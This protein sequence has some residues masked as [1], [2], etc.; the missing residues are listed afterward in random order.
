[1]NPEYVPGPY[2]EYRGVVEID[3]TEGLPE[4]VRATIRPTRFLNDRDFAGEGDE[5]PPPA[6][7]APQPP[8][9]ASGPVSGPG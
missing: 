7:G 5:V 6:D 4:E 9:A 3:F 2:D 8:P 1:M